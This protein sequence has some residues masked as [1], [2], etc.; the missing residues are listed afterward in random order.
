MHHA[1]GDWSLARAGIGLRIIRDSTA[2][3]IR[4]RWSR[5]LAAT[6]SSTDAT[7]TRPDGRSLVVRG[8]V[9]GAIERAKLLL[10]ESE[11]HGAPRR[12]V[13]VH[14]ITIHELGHALG[15]SHAPRETRAASVMEPR[16]VA[17]EVTGDDLRVLRA[18][19]AL[20]V[21][22]RCVSSSSW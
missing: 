22:L 11:A 5:S 19:Y 21:G 10:G 17:D 7:V 16:V 20:P 6:P 3:E 1:V 15:L 9:S 4:V 13:D 8:A 12:P 14:A 2:A 18:W